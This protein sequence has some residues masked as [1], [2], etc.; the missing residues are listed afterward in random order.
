MIRN[1]LHEWRERRGISMEALAQRV[2]TSRTTIHRLETT[3]DGAIHAL[4]P[5][6]CRELGIRF[7]DLFSDEMDDGVEI[8]LPGQSAIRFTPPEGHMLSNAPLGPNENIF[9]L[10]TD[11]LA[12]IGLYRGDLVIS[13]SRPNLAAVAMTGDAV[14]A[15]LVNESQTP[16]FIHRQFVGPQLLIPNGPDASVR[17]LHLTRDSV[18][19]VGIVRQRVGALRIAQ[20]AERT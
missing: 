20:R 13:E 3:S 7:S 12:E 19:L 15:Q 6:I 11:D 4:V 16:I 1:R 9:Q 14:V 17:N 5:V 2:G 18:T 10:L 8:P